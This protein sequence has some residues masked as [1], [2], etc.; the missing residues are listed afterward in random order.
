MPCSS[1][2]C[3]ACLRLLPGQPKVGVFS[4]LD[5]AMKYSGSTE[6]SFF[7]SVAATLHGSPY[8]QV[9]RTSTSTCVCARMHLHVV[10]TC[11]YACACIYVHAQVSAMPGLLLLAAR[12]IDDGEELFLDYALSNGNSSSV[13]P[14]YEPVDPAFREGLM[15]SLE[16]ELAA[17]TTTTTPIKWHGPGRIKAA[18]KEHLTR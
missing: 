2:V 5:E 18:H 15:R 8:A 3:C 4:L 11:M 16:R 7:T 13:P 6:A 9:G 14:W 12:G 1:T 17:T 10:C